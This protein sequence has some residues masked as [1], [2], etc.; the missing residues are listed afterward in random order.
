MI[1]EWP[2]VTALV[3]VA[4]QVDVPAV[5]RNAGVLD[6]IRQFQRPLVPADR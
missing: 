3:D 4:H 6:H 5:G 2:A 1:R